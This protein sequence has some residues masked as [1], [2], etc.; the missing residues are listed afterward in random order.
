MVL[1]SYGGK[2]EISNPT[3]PYWTSSRVGPIVADNNNSSNSEQH[4]Q[5]KKKKKNVKHNVSST[6]RRGITIEVSFGCSR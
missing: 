2:R 6:P 4:Q 5:Q 3:M 1:V